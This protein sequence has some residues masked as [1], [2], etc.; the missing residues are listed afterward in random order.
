MK[1]QTIIAAEAMRAPGTLDTVNLRPDPAGRPLLRPVGRPDTVAP[2]SHRPL[3]QFVGTDGT[4]QLLTATPD[5]TL[6][7]CDPDGAAPEAFHRSDSPALS[8]VFAEGS[9]TVL[10]AAGPLCF[11]YPSMRPAAAAAADYGHVR[12]S[13]AQG[14]R[15]IV[16]EVAPVKL[17][18]NYRQ[19][20]ALA[21][22]E[23]SAIGRTLRGVYTTAA[24]EADTLAVLFQPALARYRLLDKAGRVLFTSPP[25][26]LGATQ[27]DESLRLAIGADTF[28][29][30]GYRLEA[31]TW[32]PCIHIPAD[33]SAQVHSVRVS[34]TPPFHP[35]DPYADP[36]VT[37][38]RTSAASVV[39]ATPAR[40]GFGLGG[41]TAAVTIAE[42]IAR[43]DALE[44]TVATVPA[45][46]GTDVEIPVGL[47][48]RLA[49]ELAAVRAALARP[50]AA[51]AA[52]RALLSAPN[53]FAARCAA[54][55]AGVV[56]WGGID[57]LR[58][59]GHPLPLFAAT[60]SAT[61]G[62]EAYTAVEFADGSRAV[63]RGAAPSG[64]PLT[65]GPVLSYPAPDAVRLTVGIRPHG[66]RAVTA[67]YPLT[68]APDGRS[69]LYVHPSAQ[70]FAI[71][72]EESDALAVPDTDA[73][74]VAMPGA[75]LAASAGA[76]LAP[77]A[78]CVLPGAVVALRAAAGES[79]GWDY[80]RTRFLAFGHGGIDSV[81]L[82]AAAD[83]LAAARI[84]GRPV[85][86]GEAVADGADGTV[87]ALAGD[88]L[89]E[90]RARRASTVVRGADARSLAF[91]TARSELWMMPAP[92]AAALTEVLC[93]A[94]AP[95]RSYRRRT[96][97]AVAVVSG[98]A[99][100]FVQTAAG[101]LALH[102]ERGVPVSVAW[103]AELCPADGARTRVRA[104]ELYA[105]GTALDLDVAFSAA[106]GT[107]PEPVA[108]TLMRLG[109]ALRGPV[110]VALPMRRLRTLHAEVAGTVDADFT[111]RRIVFHL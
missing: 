86:A 5:G 39:T 40:S 90:V 92:D 3:L 106:G 56:A 33:V 101:V 23:A 47:R 4:P 12:L 31:D 17:K 1:T 88:D 94:C 68:P 22:S 43:M 71:G 28:M 48:I 52:D 32:R 13:A 34:L 63:W 49:D 107:G 69:A 7:L 100:T 41:D 110:A 66:G 38:T 89:V 59:A 95:L 54:M 42:A 87:Y 19:E 35:V 104:A 96:A 65:I 77:L 26:L 76:P 15:K 30:D 58:Y 84:D 53:G 18:G 67:V 25:V 50:V 97:A 78:A 20:S 75:V 74:S 70:P 45:T 102:R 80:G 85:T 93:T 55:A 99:G 9:L 37:L 11:D 21:A 27:W 8:A 82:N 57:V 46:P 62:Y 64:L 60:V 10:T 51:M 2:A 108:S 61:Q 6:Y 16:R 91:D 79:S 24:L 29:L 109:G 81:C 103:R 72:G 105:S 111:L 14:P 36:T 83:T 44:R 73:C 98:P